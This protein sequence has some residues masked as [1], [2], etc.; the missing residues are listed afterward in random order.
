MKVVLLHDERAVDGRPDEQDAMVQVETLGAAMRALGH[1]TLTMGFG[2]DAAGVA[3]RLQAEQPDL[4]INLVESV[5][6]HGRLIHLAPALLDTL[7]LPYTGAGT[8]A[9]F[10]SSHKLWTKRLLQSQDILTPAWLDDAGRSGG[11]PRFPGRYIVKSVWEDA[12]L[13]LD[14]DSVVDAT[15]LEQLLAAVLER[16]DRLGGEAFAESWIEGREFNLALLEEP[17]G[18]RVLPVAE[19]C[20]V[21]YPPDKPRLVGYQAKWAEGSFEYAN[22]VRR[23][24]LPPDDRALLAAMNALAL[25][26]WEA[27]DLR[28]YA[29]VD[30][31]VDAAGAP[32]V[33]EVNANP[34]LSPDAGFAAAVERAAGMNLEAVVQKV[35]DAALR[36]R[37]AKAPARQP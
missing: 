6:G 25:R 19:M 16:Q 9:M 10:L 17:T 7:R 21:D 24:D 29:R 8:E 15:G 26:C 11:S 2:L 14:D 34:C 5:G 32:Y 3:A 36:R 13:G 1:S 31:R 23:F 22:T 28:G 33:L 37:V 30:F 27:L 12:S 18:P 35:V 4:V 20:F